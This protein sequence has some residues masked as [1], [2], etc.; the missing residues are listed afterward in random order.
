MSGS[1][2]HCNR[3]V[4]DFDQLSRVR[5]GVPVLGDDEGDLLILEHDLPVGQNHLH[6]AGKGRHPGEIDGLERFRG[7]HRHYAGHCRGFGC[8]DLLD[9][10]V[11]VR[12]AGKIAIQHAGQLD[13][14]DVV[15]FALDETNILN[16]LALAAHAL[17]LFCAFGGGGGH[18][19]HSAASW[20]GTPL[21]L[22]AAY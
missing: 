16:A 5:G 6:I 13:V 3:L 2:L 12:R 10:C 18:L 19:V 17:Q 20:N 8:V 21:I 14:V 15:A 22:A 7:D 9:A 4:F 1:T 11:G